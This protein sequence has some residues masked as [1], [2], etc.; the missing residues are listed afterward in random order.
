M[1]GKRGDHKVEAYVLNVEKQLR[2][3]LGSSSKGLTVDGARNIY[4]A[5]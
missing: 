2:S 3:P 4:E 1:F 5:S